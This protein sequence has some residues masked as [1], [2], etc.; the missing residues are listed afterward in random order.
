MAT[1]RSIKLPAGST[2]TVQDWGEDDLEADYNSRI[3]DSM[4]ALPYSGYTCT[5][6]HQAYQGLNI[7]EC[8]N[9]ECIHYKGKE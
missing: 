4:A 6:G 8:T 1:I 3:E 9:P 2:F 7:I 5:C